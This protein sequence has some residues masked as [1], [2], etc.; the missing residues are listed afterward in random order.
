MASQP[1]THD[2]EPT[3]DDH[4]VLEF[5]R[6][7]FLVLPAAIDRETNERTC[8]WLD[9][10]V[11]GPG[12]GAFGLERQPWFEQ[13]MLR[14]PA[15]GGVL[16]SVLGSNFGLPTGLSSHLGLCPTEGPQPWHH[17]HDAPFGSETNFVYVFFFPQDTP[18]VSGP[19][20]L[21]SG[22]HFLPMLGI[23][24]SHGPAQ[25]GTPLA[26]PA[27]TLAVADFSVMHRRA[28]A[29]APAGVKRH[30]LKMVFWRT[31]PPRHDWL[32]APDFDLRTVLI[33]MHVGGRVIQTPVRI[34]FQ[35]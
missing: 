12:G 21:L 25:T 7:G 27:G 8:T 2:C 24:Q 29:T 11:Q 34:L 23:R 14:N 15:L 17:D 5:C 9:E 18:L 6:R 4:D 13:R 3:L 28:A 22:S 32:P 31:A 10:H 1:P 35:W 20:E 26:G 16:R 33:A 19:T 30:M